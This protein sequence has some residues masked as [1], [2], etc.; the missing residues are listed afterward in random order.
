MNEFHSALSLYGEL[1]TSWQFHR[2]VLPVFNSTGA[3]LKQTLEKQT[4]DL[5]RAFSDRLT[6]DPDYYAS[7]S[8]F[9]LFNWSE[10]SHPDIRQTKTLNLTGKCQQCAVQ[11]R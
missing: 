6:S 9:R 1:I 3:R 2:E 5:K 8:E 11:L 4:V 7:E 10:Y